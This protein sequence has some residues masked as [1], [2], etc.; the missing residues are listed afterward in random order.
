MKKIP[1]LGAATLVI[2]LL[3]ACTKSESSS[4]LPAASAPI[5]VHVTPLQ[6]EETEPVIT[7]SGQFTTDD[8]AALSFKVGGVISDVFVKEGER[9]QKGQLLAILNQAEIK[10]LVKQSELSVEKTHRDYTRTENLYRDSVAT[11]EQLQ[12]ARTAMQVAKQQLE[13][14]RFNLTFSEIRA[15]ADGY[16]LKRFVQPGQVVA[17]GAA[18]LRTNGAGKG[19]WVFKADVSDKDWAV[20]EPGDR[21]TILTDAAP[22]Q[23]IAATLIRKAEGADPVTGAFRVELAIQHNETPQLA[24]GLFGR[25]TIRANKKNKVWKVPY[26]ALLDGNA[27]TGYVFITSDHKTAQ[28]VLVS[29]S[30]LERN[31]A[32]VSGGLEQAAF[33]IT[34]GSAYLTDKA[35]ITVVKNPAQ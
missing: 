35:S 31:E 3:Q 12:N 25:A 22:G 1:F 7:T 28:R 6:K 14:A 9:I 15:A 32:Y 4:A 26:N 16:V 33:L 24:S 17:P 13:A 30:T 27:H 18:V 19:N 10:A 2:L 5:P 29:I 23:P 34:S 8:E 20:L 21:A 11:L